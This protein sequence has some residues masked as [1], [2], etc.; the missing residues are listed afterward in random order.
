M[1]AVRTIRERLALS[2]A[3]LGAALGMTQGNVSF[4]E[5]DKQPVPPPVAGKLIELAR[6]RGLEIGYDH[7]YGAAELPTPPPPESHPQPVARAA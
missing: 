5:L 4:Y 1:N 2:Q 6:D 3:Q 7:V